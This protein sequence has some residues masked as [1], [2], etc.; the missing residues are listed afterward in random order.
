M[1]RTRLLYN[2]KVSLTRLLFG[3]STASPAG[4]VLQQKGHQ[5]RTPTFPLPW[6]RLVS[7]SSKTPQKMLHMPPGSSTHEC[8]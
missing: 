4:G 7:F 8:K 1:S 5:H 6:Y 2:T 3:H